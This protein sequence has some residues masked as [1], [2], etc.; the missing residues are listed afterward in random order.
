MQ[1]R[2]Y[3]AITGASKAT[4]TRDLKHLLDIGAFTLVDSAGGRSTR[5]ALNF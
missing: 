4:A 3:I 5:Y 1:A 2:K